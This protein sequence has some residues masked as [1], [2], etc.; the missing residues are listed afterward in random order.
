MI[1]DSRHPLPVLSL[2][3]AATMW[4][5]FWY[6][7]RLFEGLGLSGL[8]SAALIY[9]GALLIGLVPA[10]RARHGFRLSPG[11]LLLLALA[12][13]WTNTGFILAM[14]EGTVA[15]ALLLFYLA[16]LWGILLAW[17]V[18]GERPARLSI[19]GV[20]LALAGA[21]FMVWEPKVGWPLP[22]DA[23]DWYALTAGMAFG[24]M[25]V[26]VRRARSV[27]LPIRLEVAWSGVLIVALSGIALYQPVVPAIEP[28]I[29]LSAMAFGAVFMVIMTLATQYGV[30][31]MP[32][33]RSA[34]ILFV[35]VLV[36][37]VTAWLL[38]GE[39]LTMREWLGGVM[40]LG[41]VYLAV[42]GRRGESLESRSTQ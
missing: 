36:G 10:W 14:L 33:Q 19:M 12:A 2:L 7:L 25:N 31:R 9:T 41:A 4:G 30:T 22:N 16:P 38:A 15:R 26:L 1:P 29:L 13:G 34:V 23:A 39:V 11:A 24:T 3:L 20:G 17:P 8:W 27:P 28:D 6:P 18:L 21:L 40:I 42:V 5:T 37:A 35:E 32:I